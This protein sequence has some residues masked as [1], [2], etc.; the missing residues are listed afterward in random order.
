MSLDL[1]ASWLLPRRVGAARAKELAFFADMVEA[2]EALRL[3]LVNRVVPPGELD[4]AVDDWAR[5]LA[6]GPPLALSMTKAL[7]DAAWSVSLADAVEAEAHAQAVNAATADTKEAV[8]A[9]LAKRD[10]RFEGR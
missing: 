7:L 10:A 9:F 5:R 4:A 6:D 3:G 8:A 2:G 1:G